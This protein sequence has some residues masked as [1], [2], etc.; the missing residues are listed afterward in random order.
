[1]SVPNAPTIE[2]PKATHA[3]DVA[4]HGTSGR[5][6][7]ARRNLLLFSLPA[8]FFYV[9]F[10]VYPLANTMLLSL[11][12]VNKDG[13]STSFTGL[14]NYV[15]LFTNPAFSTT[16]FNA[17][18]NNIQFFL[19]HLLV[20]VPIG[21]ALAAL[22]TSGATR[23][24]TR[25]YLLLLFIPAT[26]SVVI[27]AFM[28]RMIISP[29]WGIVSFPLLGTTT[30]AL[31]TMSLMSVW[32]YVGIPMVFLYTALLAIPDD[33]VEAARIDSASGWRVFWHVKLPLIAPQFA[34]IAILTFIWTFI[35]F[36]I[37]FV[38][39]GADPGPRHSTDIF[40]TLFYRTFYGWQA[41]PGDPNMGA[42]VATVIFM[43]IL[44]VT[45]AYF[46]F[47]MRRQHA[48]EY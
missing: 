30:T 42:T 11:W 23:R 15:K 44:I 46:A 39:A 2:R 32:Q 1:M 12:K 37:V 16:F 26:L 25:A 36:D 7:T 6:R 41:Q 35:G 3:R 40:G 43:T 4:P 47:V 9:V 10:L 13:A 31:P 14:G 38:L 34:L 21:L 22:L 33:L 28:W 8:L 29:L 27:T 48:Y 5:A 17:F 20:E 24:T 18:T 45:A 19:I